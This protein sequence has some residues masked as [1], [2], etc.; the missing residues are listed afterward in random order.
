M[1]ASFSYQWASRPA[2]VWAARIIG[3]LLALR[4][5]AWACELR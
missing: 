1:N 4:W 3:A 2:F 5:L